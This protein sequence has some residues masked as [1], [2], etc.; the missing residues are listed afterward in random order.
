MS[1][2]YPELKTYM[3]E[4]VA[5]LPLFVKN[6]HLLQWQRYKTFT[7][8]TNIFFIFFIFFSFFFKCNSLQRHIL[9]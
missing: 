5:F 7:T 2:H 9:S 6:F 3:E 4:N 8:L 1:L